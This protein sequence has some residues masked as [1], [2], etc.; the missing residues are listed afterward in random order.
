MARRHNR[1]LVSLLVGCLF[2][3]A[4]ATATI[5]Q[6]VSQPHEYPAGVAQM[7]WHVMVHPHPLTEPQ[8][9]ECATGALV[10]QRLVLGSRGGE[11]VGVDV[12][13]GAVDWSIRVQ[14]GV[15]GDA[16]YDRSRGQVY[17]G[18]DD[19]YL[20]AIEPERGTVRWSSKVKGAIEHAPDVGE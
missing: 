11:V 5:G 12:G 20:Y 15:D 13:T 6:E 14:G 3:A 18:T 16:A 19:G 2:A 8:P 9:E 1:S 4:C 10:G 17:L 7:R